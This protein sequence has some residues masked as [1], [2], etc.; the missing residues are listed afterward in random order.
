MNIINFPIYEEI[1]EPYIA[2][3]IDDPKEVKDE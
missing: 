1:P 2:K 3:P